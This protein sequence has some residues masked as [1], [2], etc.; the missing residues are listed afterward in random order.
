MLNA[1]KLA[2]MALAGTQAVDITSQAQTSL[3]AT[4][5][6]GALAQITLDESEDGDHGML[7]QTYAQFNLNNLNFDA[8]SFWNDV[9]SWA[10]DS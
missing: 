9:Q 10:S 6:E 2:A 4:V 7:A 3:S 1:T 5:D 8:N